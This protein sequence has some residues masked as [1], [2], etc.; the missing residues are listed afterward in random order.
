MNPK[1]NLHN[2]EEVYLVDRGIKIFKAKFQKT[3]DKTVHGKEINDSK[4]RFFITKVLTNASK[5]H[6]FDMDTNVTGAAI[7]WS[8]T[9][10]IRMKLVDVSESSGTEAT[11]P[12]QREK[13]KKKRNPELWK[14][15]VKKKKTEQWQRL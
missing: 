11:P 13:K 9:D 2:N 3:D 6:A 14:T 5:W 8:T 7:L 12:T 15:A 4:G 1:S 10:I